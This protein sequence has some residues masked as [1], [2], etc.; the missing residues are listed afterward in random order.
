[1]TPEE[2][3]EQ[4]DRDVAHWK[5][6]LAGSLSARQRS[7]ASAELTFARMRYIRAFFAIKDA[8]EVEAHEMVAA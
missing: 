7:H 3:F 6:I 5:L 2:R 8:Q 4:A 1:M